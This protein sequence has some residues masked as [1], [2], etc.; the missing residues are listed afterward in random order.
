MDQH[1]GANLVGGADEEIG[2]P[3]AEQAGVRV[4]A[5]LLWRKKWTIII[6]VVIAVVGVLA[7]CVAASKKYTATSTV[8]LEPQISALINPAQNNSNP[9]GT[10]NVPNVIQVIESQS[11]KDLVARTIPNPPS[12]TATE[13]G[14]AGTTTVV[15]IS[16]TSTSPQTAAAAANAYANAYINSQ[17]RLT[18]ATFNAAESQ[19]QNKIDTV[20]IAISNVDDQIRA[21]PAGTSTNAQ[22]LELSNLESTL[23]GLQNEL[24]QYQF[25]GSQGLDTE[26]GQLISQASVPTSPSSPKTVEYTVLAFL[27]A[28]VIGIGVVLVINA[29]TTRR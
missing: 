9:I 13:A 16:T 25:Y 7:Y 27:F 21:A 1:A 2:A 17:K 28:L 22:D 24:E 15:E 14:L 8:L 6:V 20:Q 12:A 11:I 18:T 26:V 5:N 29:V 4:Y 23:T 19:L 10:I 3:K